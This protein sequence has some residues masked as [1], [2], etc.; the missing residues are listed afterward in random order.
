MNFP[1]LQIVFGTHL[2]TKAVVSMSST[3]S[4]MLAS[5]GVALCAKKI[6]LHIHECMHVDNGITYFDFPFFLATVCFFD[7]GAIELEQR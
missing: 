3:R 5:A 7:F 6:Q 4:G 1:P 2:L